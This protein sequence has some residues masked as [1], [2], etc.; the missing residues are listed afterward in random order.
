MALA[1]LEEIL[2]KFPD[3]DDEKR[4]FAEKLYAEL[5]GSLNREPLSEKTRENAT[6]RDTEEQALAIQFH[7]ALHGGMPRD[8]LENEGVPFTGEVL[9]RSER[10]CDTL[11]NDP[12]F[13]AILKRL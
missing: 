13:Q 2:K 12:K 9:A 4:Q 5:S 10:R 3:V 7:N 6:P 11:I 8:T 1:S